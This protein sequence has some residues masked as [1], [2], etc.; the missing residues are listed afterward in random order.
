MYML[1]LKS[2]YW[3]SFLFLSIIFSLSSITKSDELNYYPLEVVSFPEKKLNYKFL[4]GSE[5]ID[6]EITISK[7]FMLINKTKINKEQV[8][9]IKNKLICK[10]EF[11]FSRCLPS[12]IKDIGFKKITLIF[13]Q[14]EILQAKLIFIKD[15]V[16]ANEFSNNL[17]KWLGWDSL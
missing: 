12:N 7:D 2:I 1:N 17:K 11:G 5:K 8:K 14:N 3:Y 10:N 4:C 6:C 15:I 9:N 16:V 13:Y